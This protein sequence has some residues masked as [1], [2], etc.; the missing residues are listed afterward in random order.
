MFG[1]V[2]PWRPSVTAAQSSLA[3]HACVVDRYIMSICLLNSEAF[4]GKLIVTC[5]TRACWLCSANDLSAFEARSVS[6]SCSCNKDYC[7]ATPAML[8]ESALSAKV[9][10][11][12]QEIQGMDSTELNL[13]HF[14]PE[15]GVQILDKLNCNGSKRFKFIDIWEFRPPKL[16]M[17][18]HPMRTTTSFQI[19][20]KTRVDDDTRG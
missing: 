6:C 15:P 3:F 19:P 10:E 11:V 16:F 8:S 7:R 5:E 13:A 1:E 12:A 2:W 14:V 20:K 4:P 18:A 9:D 17:C